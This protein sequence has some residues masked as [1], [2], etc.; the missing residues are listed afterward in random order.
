M[1]YTPKVPNFVPGQTTRCRDDHRQ[2]EQRRGSRSLRGYNSRWDRAARAFRQ[3]YP[4][5][6]L[7]PA[8]LAPVMSRC[9][10][11]GRTTAA[12]QTD[13]VVPHKGDPTL[14]WDSAGNWQSLCRACGAAKSQAGL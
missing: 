6:G 14:F 11:E 1:P 3:R 13:H 7:R 9:F 2:R 8:G 4:L 5:C 10:A 12:Y